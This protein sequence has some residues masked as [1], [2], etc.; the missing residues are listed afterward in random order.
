MKKQ[1]WKVNELVKESIR[2]KHL[3]DFKPMIHVDIQSG[4]IIF[5]NRAAYYGIYYVKA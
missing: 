4:K 1:G 3:D 2:D 5:D